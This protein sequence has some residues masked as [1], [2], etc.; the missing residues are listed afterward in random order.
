MPKKRITASFKPEPQVVHAIEAAGEKENLSNAE[1]I[2]QCV[3]FG[4]DHIAKGDF[5]LKP[6]RYLRSDAKLIWKTRRQNLKENKG[7]S[8]KHRVIEDYKRQTASDTP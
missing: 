4:L 8:G 1:V 3:E 2:R 5:Q 6:A 7:R